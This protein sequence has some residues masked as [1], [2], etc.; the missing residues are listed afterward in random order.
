VQ[1][2]YAVSV[3]HHSLGEKH[4]SPAPAIR[5][6]LADSSI[7]PNPDSS[8]AYDDLVTRGLERLWRE[9]LIHFSKTK[10]VWR[11]ELRR[12][13]ARRRTRYA[14]LAQKS[15]IMTRPS[16]LV[17]ARRLAQKARFTEVLARARHCPIMKCDLAGIA[18]ARVLAGVERFL[19]RRRQAWM[20]KQRIVLTLHTGA[21]HRSA[22]KTQLAFV[23][24]ACLLARLIGLG[25]RLKGLR[26]GTKGR[27]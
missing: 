17:G 11:R 20:A 1:H 12:H 14:R 24:D 27:A 19:R 4:C 25:W 3:L 2:C 10:V 22:A 23:I 9:S 26:Q 5:K 7:V 21:A 18:F 6:R 8:I 15:S 13:T 16:K